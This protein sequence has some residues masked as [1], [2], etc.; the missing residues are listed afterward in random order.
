MR[1][2]RW[3]VWCLCGWMYAVQDSLIIIRVERCG[4]KQAVA[5]IQYASIGQGK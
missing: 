3:M 4:Y 5:E 2:V 1:F